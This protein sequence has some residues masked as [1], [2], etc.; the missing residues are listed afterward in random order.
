MDNTA[1]L[2]EK[3]CLFLQS[4]FSV[5]RK[6]ERILSD[7]VLLLAVS[8]NTINLPLVKDVIFYLNSIVIFDLI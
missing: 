7:V 1:G 5:K 3:H 8:T 4:G 2:E 6:I